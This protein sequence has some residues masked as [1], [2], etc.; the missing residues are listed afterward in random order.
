VSAARHVALAALWA[1]A[2]ANEAAT[3]RSDGA[4]A[5]LALVAAVDAAAADAAP[6][7]LS[8]SAPLPTAAVAL[9]NFHDFRQDG[10]SW[11]FVSDSEQVLRVTPYGD[12][13]VRVQ[14]AP[15]GQ[16][17]VADNRYQMVESHALGG[18]LALHDDG[19]TFTLSGA[20]LRVIVNK[21][22][23]RL[24]FV[25]A[26]ATV[27][28][29]GI[30]SGDR[31]M[32][33]EVN[34][35]RVVD[36]LSF[37]P[38]GAWTTWSTVA[39]PVSLQAGRNL[40]R[41]TDIGASGPNLDYLDVDTIGRFE[42]EAA[43][44][45][46]VANASSNA[47]FSG[48][49]YADPQHESGDSIEFPLQVLDAGVY[50]LRFGYANGAPAVAHLAPTA[51][52]HFA[53]LGH[54]AYGRVDQIDLAGQVIARNRV[55]QAP[56][57]VPFYLS[58]R[59]YGMFVNSPQ[60]N[61]FSFLPNDYQFNIA[62][63]QMDYF[64]IAG[65]SLPSVIDHYTELTGRP[66]LPPLAAFGLGLSDKLDNTLPS[67]EVW[68]KD[69]VMQLRAGGWPFDVIIHDNCWRGG[70]TAPWRWDLTRYPDPT[71][72]AAWSVA[73][74]VINMLDFNRADDTL[75]DGW[76]PA[77]ALP[78]TTD[79]PDFSSALVRDWFWGLLRSQTFD[80]ALHR[81]GD[82][83][84]LDEPD[85]DV[86]PSGPL[87]D[88]RSW[89]EDANY[90][91]FLMAKSVGE[92]WSQTFGTSKRTFIMSRGM[93]AG[94]QRWAGLWTGDINNSYTE[95]AE[96]IRGM[97]AAG[98][99]GF[100]FWSHD[101]GGFWAL[102]SDSMYRQ[103][104]MS[105]GSF[106]PI[107][108]PH[109]QGLRFPW[110]FSAAAQADARKYGNLRMTLLPYLYSLAHEAHASGLPMARA[111]LLD[112][113]TD[114]AAWVADREYLWGPRLLVAPA[115]GDGG[116]SVSVW[117]PPGSWYDYWDDT[118]PAM[119]GGRTISYPA[120]TGTLPLLV[121]AGA[122]LPEAVGT[123]ASTHAWDRS[124]LMVQ[125]YTGDSGQ[126]TV[127]EDD[128]VTDAFESGA[129][130]RT[131]LTY[132][133]ATMTL[134]IAP[135]GGSYTGAPST[136]SYQAHFHGLP[137]QAGVRLGGAV[138]PTKSAWADA[139][140]AG[141]GAVWNGA[142]H[143]LSVYAGSFA[144]DAKVTLERA[145]YEAEAATL[146]GPVAHSDNAGYSGSGYADYQNLTGDYVEF[147]VNA[148]RADT[149]TLLF[150][151]ANGAG[152]RPLEVHVNGGAAQ[153]V[154]FPSTGS[155]TTWQTASVTVTLAAGVNAIRA[156]AGGA[157]GPNLDR[158][159]VY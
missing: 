38:T 106:S 13:M 12:A 60:R 47:G 85:E 66:R 149:Y 20:S 120:P 115:I 150:R 157:G 14:V 61:Q 59:G 68:W 102:P 126:F 67:D 137:A 73:N 138:L 34:G 119:A 49:G 26:G 94:A 29:L 87:A 50:L 21:R 57:L 95:M 6:P 114:P 105:M 146:S 27:E 129:E 25:A 96:Q 153:I 148:A 79:W 145:R 11:V 139:I 31:P 15:A 103:W 135:D 147:S 28:D 56:L 92:G 71:E 89:D 5:D 159:D 112:S 52:E 53:G 97:Q 80:P 4:A 100:P 151:Y 10:R 37:P 44:L 136:R 130:T 90:Y 111:M 88:G 74:N 8:P 32:M 123:L 40:V 1:A 36:H 18:A 77:Y 17:L 35:A 140:A 42:A 72:F 46:G 33:L 48:S 86:A 142:T 158:L 93:G 117:L 127:R 99:S 107:W 63:G 65:P 84:W 54:G 16:E 143:V 110:L 45:I 2:C 124:Q 78:G 55:Y 51:G 41:L 133:D 118:A 30:E 62:A 23:L 81:P 19:P 132:T 101:A 131:A 156:V 82:L 152:D 125:V 3:P 24:R 113:P 128:G 104:S 83:L 144:P 109:G 58:S 22:P 98:L 121:R 7:D 76:Q 75:S 108:R 154:S 116:G 43:S 64:F 134:E 141:G 9:T 91:F 155:W 69:K 122:L 70:K 39:V